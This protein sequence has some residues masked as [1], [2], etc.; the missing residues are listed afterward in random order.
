MRLHIRHLLLRFVSVFRR[1]RAEADLT[2]EIDAHLRL[3][4]DEFRGRGMP[5]VEARRAARRAF[6]GVEQ[7]KEQQRD[8][9]SFRLLENSW[10]DAK[11]GARMLVK[12][13]GLTI[14]GGLGMAVAIALSAAA[15]SMI[16]LMLRPVL[17]L[18]DG[19]RI[20]SIHP[21][22]R[23]VRDL[24][25]WR[26]ALPSLVD[27]G[28]FRQ[29]RRNLIAPGASPHVLTVAEMTATGFRLARVA[30]LLGRP[31]VESDEQPGAPDVA[32]IGYE[33][34][35]DHF[36]SDPAVL[37]RSLRLG[38]V[39]HD[40]VGVMPEG[41]RFPVNDALWVALRTEVYKDTLPAGP[42]IHIFARIAPGMTKETA[43]AE[44]NV[45][46][47][48]MADDTPGS[49][50]SLRPRVVPYAYPFTD[51]DDPENALALALV[52]ALVLL[53]VT[54]V[55]V[56]VAILVYARTTR[57]E[58]ELLIRNAIGASRARIVAQL[59][60][61]ALLLSGV[62]AMVGL[63]LVHVGL[64]QVNGAILRL[65]PEGP[66]FW[67]QFSVDWQTVLYIAATALL[68]TAVVGI[69]PALK[70]TRW[71]VQGG[72]Q[73]LSSGGGSS[74]HLGGTWTLLIIGQVACAVALLAPAVFFTWDAVRSRT[75]TY[76]RPATDTLTALVRLDS[77]TELDRD[78][79]SEVFRRRFAVRQSDLLLRLASEPRIADVTV[80][81]A[82]PGTEGAGVIEIEGL[83]RPDQLADYRLVDGSALGHLIRLNRVGPN[84]FETFD[85]PLLAGRTFRGDDAASG[86]SVIVVNRTF[87]ERFGGEQGVLGRAVRYVGRTGDTGPEDVVLGRRYEVVGV[88]ADYPSPP[89]ADRA[90]TVLY[91]PAAP[92][93]VYPPV[94]SVRT[95]SRDPQQ[96]AGRIR[97]ITAE[98]DPNLQLVDI[99]SMGDRVGREDGLRRLVAG[100]LAG[101]TLSVL[102]LSAAGIYALMSFTVE[103]RRK[104]IGI[105]SALGANPARI[106][107]S[108][109]SRTLA[110]LGMGGVLGLLVAVMIDSASGGELIGGGAVWV[111]PSVVAIMCLVGL[112]ATWVPARRGLRVSPTEA[113]RE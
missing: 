17:P 31:I 6:G 20:V 22:T 104:E 110:Q 65:L 11:L 98:V 8:A 64:R 94:L 106:I 53:L 77:G 7:A 69:L 103:R 68:A 92:G 35:R 44:V 99:V 36:G 85:V 34:W 13:P 111:L 105:R 72:L 23:P 54:A 60:I 61:E 101:V 32:V 91:H 24:P 18:D 100:T 71:S 37:E 107:G 112:V 83:T 33:L 47:A 81:V 67:I 39:V 52:Q 75:A 56:N 45:F 9:R 63:G 86:A 93:E 49:Q 48:Q 88:V 96:L 80:S 40:I 46:A 5:D 79:G 76:G 87:A 90:S 84:F 73:R 30:P 1:H 28:A 41:F 109:F 27:V 78:K 89:A 19:H 25:T 82:L 38:D 74:M 70:A 4:E 43:Q 51:M 113:L 15:F 3:L 26:T 12:S 21:V 16:S 2:R 108:I 10:L 66:P 97:Q 59:F 62:S 55:A 102:G 50:P 42:S 57:R 14:I 95:W 29:V 58:A